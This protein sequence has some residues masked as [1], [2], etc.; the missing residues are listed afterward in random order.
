[1]QSLN[2]GGADVEYNY[3]LT[4]KGIYYTRQRLVSKFFRFIV[5]I[6]AWVGI[7][8]C[9]TGALVVGPMALIGA[10]A[11]VF[12]FFGM[13]NLNHKVPVEHIIYFAGDYTLFD[14]KDRAQIRLSNDHDHPEQRSCGQIYC[15]FTDKN[16]L[17]EHLKNRF[18]F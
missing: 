4:P 10:G 17:I 1:M 7:F 12:M 3:H 15:S 16:T 8:V 9:I 11:I 13:V 5:P 18:P 14:L 6:I 2:S